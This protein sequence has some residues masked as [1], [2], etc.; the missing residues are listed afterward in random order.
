MNFHAYGN[1]LNIP[2]NF[3]NT[4]GFG[5]ADL[6]REYPHIY[7]YLEKVYQSAPKGSRFGSR[8]ENTGR[9][10][11]GEISDWMFGEHKIFAF[12]PEL[13]SQDISTFTYYI[14]SGSTLKNM[15][16]ENHKMVY[17]ACQTLLP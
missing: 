17:F 16:D 13:G 15:L 9:P 10:I 3:E 7:Q 8:F 11:N 5:N 1:N 6:K 14:R 4:E 12:S 2:Y